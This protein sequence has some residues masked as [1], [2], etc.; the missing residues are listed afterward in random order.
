MRPHTMSNKPDTFL[1]RRCTGSSRPSSGRSAA[2]MPTTVFLRYWPVGCTGTV[3]GLWTA[4]T[5]GVSA[6]VYRAHNERESQDKLEANGI[7]AK[8]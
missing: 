1:S 5:S 7:K 3:A 2:R 6:V 4:T 8:P